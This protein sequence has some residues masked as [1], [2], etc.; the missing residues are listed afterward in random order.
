MK[1]ITILQKNTEAIT[2]KDADDS[3]INEYT[4]KLSKVLSIGNVCVLETS[5]TNVI[6]RP[7]QI[8]SILV[9]DD[10][11]PKRKT[12]IPKPKNKSKKPIEEDIVT[13]GD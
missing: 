9:E 1:N 11:S 6:L 2:I 3:D 8:V 10:V 7:N 5:T 13:D 4:Q 12:I